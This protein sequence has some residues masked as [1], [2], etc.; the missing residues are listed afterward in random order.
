[1]CAMLAMSHQPMVCPVK[2][3]VLHDAG[4]SKSF[5]SPQLV[6][7]VPTA[8]SVIVPAEP[9]PQILCKIHRQLHSATASVAFPGVHRKDQKWDAQVSIPLLRICIVHSWQF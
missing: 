8:L 9:V 1:M 6:L 3:I 2:V 7:Q 5:F 4:M